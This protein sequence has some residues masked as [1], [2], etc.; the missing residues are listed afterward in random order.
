VKG[1]PFTEGD[2]DRVL[3]ELSYEEIQIKRELAE[4][5]LLAD[6]RINDLEGIVKQFLSDI[7]AGLEWLDKDTRTKEEADEKFQERKEI[8]RALIANV[9]LRKSRE[10]EILFRLDLS[11]I[12]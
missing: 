12:L 4:L 11:P 3:E 7:R 8:V 6:S 5:E 10:P 1:G 9:I 2:L